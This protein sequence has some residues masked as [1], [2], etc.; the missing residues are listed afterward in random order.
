MAWEIVGHWS[1]SG[2]PASSSRDAVRDIIGDVFA[3]DP[4]LSDEEINAKLAVSA[5]TM[6]AGAMCC[7]A[8]A[9][10]C[11]REVDRTNSP[12]GGVS[13]TVNY[14]QRA[15]AFRTLA[16]D[17]RSQ[18]ALGIGSTSAGVAPYAGGISIADKASREADSDRVVP[19][20]TVDSFANP[21]AA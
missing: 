13:Q 5:V 7:D 19:A 3:D 12:Q 6:L 9:A 10:R 16:G 4:L 1:Y 17:L 2:D 14:S 15:K 21:G 18:Y 20:F 8:I 11:S